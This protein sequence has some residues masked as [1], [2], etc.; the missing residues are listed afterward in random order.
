MPWEIFERQASRYEHW[1]A[2]TRGRRVDRSERAL[3]AWLLGWFPAARRVLEIGCGTGH[4]TEWLGERECTSIG[5]DRSPAMLREARR[6]G[7]GSPLVLGDAHRLPLRDRAVDVAALIATLEFLDSPALA[8]QESVRVAEH[9]LV[10]VVLNR[11]SLG[12][13]S[14]RWGPASRGGLLG[15]ARDLSLRRLRRDIEAAAGA[16]L[17]GMH[18]RSTLLPRPFDRLVAPVP[19]GDVIGVAVELAS[20]GVPDAG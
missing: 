5:L 17:R 14:R 7:S 15:R 1:Y 4:F 13:A 16:R 2:T 11:W 9:G 6:H 10:F 18:W 19:L 12:A 8:L 20:A 3:L